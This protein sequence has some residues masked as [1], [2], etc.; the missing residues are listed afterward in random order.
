[1]AARQQR[2]T[3]RLLRDYFPN[4]TDL[5]IHTPEHLAAVAAQ[6]NDRPRKVLDW[7]TPAARFATLLEQAHRR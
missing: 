4:G 2:N 7:D 5:T 1:M 3:N 6:L